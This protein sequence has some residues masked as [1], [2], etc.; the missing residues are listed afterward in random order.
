MTCLHLKQVNAE[1]VGNLHFFVTMEE[2]EL[3]ENEATQNFKMIKHQGFSLFFQEA[4]SHIFSLY[5]FI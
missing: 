3:S 2:A 5:L 4:T 1:D